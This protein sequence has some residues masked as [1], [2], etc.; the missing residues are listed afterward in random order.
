MNKESGN[1]LRIKR[2]YKNVSQEKMAEDLNISRSKV[3]SWETGRRD[4]CMQDAIMVA[5]YFN[6]D[7]NSIFF[8]E[9]PNSESFLEMA[10]NY[11]KNPKIE[12][13]QKEIMFIKILELKQ[14]SEL[15]YMVSQFDSK[16]K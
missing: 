16:S 4:I 15:E 11:F 14:E 6:T 12:Y 2:A 3:S 1:N 10:K 7:L 9:V 13:K 5:K 8:N